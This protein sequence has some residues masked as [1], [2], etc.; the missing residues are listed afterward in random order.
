MIS[1]NRLVSSKRLA[2]KMRPANWRV[3]C[4]IPAGGAQASADFVDPTQRTGFG[5]CARGTRSRLRALSRAAPRSA[6]DSRAPASLLLDYCA[7]T[8]LG[9]TAATPPGRILVRI[10]ALPRTKSETPDGPA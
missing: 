5:D 8:I 3:L 4:D 9:G 10:G 6:Y 1:S 2:R 7:A